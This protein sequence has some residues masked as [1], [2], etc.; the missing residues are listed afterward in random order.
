MKIR[1]LY[2]TGNGFT[3]CITCGSLHYRDAAHPLYRF[4]CLMPLQTTSDGNQYVWKM[5]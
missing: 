3:A 5:R 4:I 2:C 1:V